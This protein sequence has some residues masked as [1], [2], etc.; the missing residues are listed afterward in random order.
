[1]LEYESGG[2]KS[3]VLSQNFNG[4]GIFNVDKEYICQD[5]AIFHLT[6]RD[7]IADD[8]NSYKIGCRSTGDFEMS[9]WIDIE[10][11]SKGCYR[12]DFKVYYRIHYEIRDIEMI[13]FA[14]IRYIYNINS[15]SELTLDGKRD[16]LLGGDEFNLMAKFDNVEF[17]FNIPFEENYSFI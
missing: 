4:N 5:T 7:K 13:S 3:E 10:L 16:E 11:E 8:R 6:E 17:T 2:Q 9:P 1:M 14:Q 12:Q 15:P